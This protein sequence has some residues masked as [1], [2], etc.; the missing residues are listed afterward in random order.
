MPDA[1]PKLLKT[2]TY[3]LFGFTA[4]KQQLVAIDQTN[5]RQ[6]VEQVFCDDD[7]CE[8]Y[9]CGQL[10]SPVEMTVLDR[11]VTRLKIFVASGCRCGF[12]RPKRQSRHKQGYYYYKKKPV[13]DQTTPDTMQNPSTPDDSMENETTLG[14][15]DTTTGNGP[16]DSTD[17]GMFN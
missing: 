4:Q 5:L 8:G 10:F 17:Q 12:K 2:V 15:D 3:P 9:E 13:S 11:Q 14:S 1:C 6:E 7:Y 16:S